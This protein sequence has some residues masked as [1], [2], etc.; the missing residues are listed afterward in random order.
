MAEAGKDALIRNGIIE[1]AGSEVVRGSR[2]MTLWRLA[3][4]TL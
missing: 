2:R 3:V 1:R 4:P